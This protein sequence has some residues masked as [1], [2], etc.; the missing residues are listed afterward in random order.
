[1]KGI[2]V[3]DEHLACLAIGVVHI[4]VEDMTYTVKYKGVVV[5]HE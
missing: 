1:V 5:Q 3:V 4:E 2:Q